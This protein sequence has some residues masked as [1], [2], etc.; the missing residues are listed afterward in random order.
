VAYNRTADYEALLDW[1]DGKTIAP[2][3]TYTAV[4]GSIGQIKTSDAF[5]YK[6]TVMHHILPSGSSLTSVSFN[7]TSAN[8]DHWRIGDSFTSTVEAFAGPSL[9][10]S[11]NAITERRFRAAPAPSSET[12]TLNK[13]DLK[14]S[15]GE[16]VGFRTR[17]NKYTENSALD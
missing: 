12:A 7:I 2:N 5:N 17:W 1:F 11:L 15:I 6:T 3:N 13:D 4:H 14:H 8:D 16:W 9:E 10:Y